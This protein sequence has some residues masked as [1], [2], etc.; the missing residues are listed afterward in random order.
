MKSIYRDRLRKL[1]HYLKLSVIA[2]E[3]GIPS[4]TLSLFMKDQAYN[5]VLSVNKLEQ[6]LDRIDDVLSECIL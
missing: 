4:S 3:I 2:K 5:Y 1:K 6:L